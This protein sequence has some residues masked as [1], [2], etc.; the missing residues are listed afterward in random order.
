MFRGLWDEFEDPYSGVLSLFCGF[1]KLWGW[2]VWSIFFRFFCLII[3]FC[4]SGNISHL[5]L[6]EQKQMFTKM[7]YTRSQI[8]KSFSIGRFLVLRVMVCRKP[9]V[10]LFSRPPARVPLDFFAFRTFER[11]GFLTQK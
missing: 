8:P 9:H 10:F 1:L 3:S 6:P 4:I 2:S 11:N 7:V 5:L